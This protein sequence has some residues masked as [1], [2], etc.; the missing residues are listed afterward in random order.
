[1][2]RGVRATTKEWRSCARAFLASR[3]ILSVQQK[4]GLGY[5]R[6]CKILN[7]FREIMTEDIPEPFSGISE[8]DETFIGGKWANKRRHIRSHKSKRGHGTDKLPV[9]GVYSRETKQVAVRI[10]EKRCEETVIGFMCSRLAKDSLLYTDG[11][12]MNRAVKKY[13]VKHEYVNHHLGEYVRGTIHTNSIEGFWGYLKR[14]LAIIGGIR[15][16]RIY[17]FVGEITWRF[18][19]RQITPEKQIERLIHLLSRK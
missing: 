8:A 19:H 16:D 2:V 11:Y 3:T 7:V 15:R 5:E 18:N 1:V 9:V 12:K 13:G 4:T 6:V 10:V 14:R 17:L